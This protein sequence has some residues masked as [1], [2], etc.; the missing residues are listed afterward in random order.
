MKQ[1]HQ[2]NNQTP[3]IPK[4]DK[5]GEY[6]NDLY[7]KIKEEFVPKS[8]FG[9]DNKIN[10][11]EKGKSFRKSAKIRVDT[12]NDSSLIRNF[13]KEHINRVEM[14]QS[15][16]QQIKNLSNSSQATIE[17]KGRSASPRVRKIETKNNPTRDN[18]L[19]GDGIRR[20]EEE[21]GEKALEDLGNDIKK[22]MRKFETLEKRITQQKPE[23]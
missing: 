8:I 4:G 12:Q 5:L 11:E 18:F 23:K 17:S 16:G 20:I 6:L 9:S 2:Q 22:I 13:Q 19:N 21:E 10:S 1:P 7:V 14:T 3:L 15:E